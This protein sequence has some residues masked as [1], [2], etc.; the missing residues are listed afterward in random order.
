VESEAALF[1]AL[2]DRTRRLI[3][4]RD[5]GASAADAVRDLRA[6]HDAARLI[7]SRQ[8]VSQHLDALD[9]PD[10]QDVVQL[11]LEPDQHLAVRAAKTALVADGVP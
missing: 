7:S 3:S 5:G 9:A 1:R 11:L 10:D 4:G 8:A 6:A 2:S